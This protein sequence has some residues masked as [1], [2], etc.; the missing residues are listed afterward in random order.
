MLAVCVVMLVQSI[1]V[2]VGQIFEHFS[3]IPIQ[4]LTCFVNDDSAF[5]REA[6]RLH[7]PDYA[8]DDYAVEGM[9]V[10]R[11]VPQE[12]N[13]VEIFAKFTKRNTSI[14]TMLRIFDGIDNAEIRECF[15]SMLL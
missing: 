13:T 6:L 8:L 10:M 15:R 5:V 12:F 3:S 9:R 1:I 4:I 2:V 14:D 7:H 11:A